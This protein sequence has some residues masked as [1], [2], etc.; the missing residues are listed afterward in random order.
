MPIVPSSQLS[1]LSKTQLERRL[2]GAAHRDLS[3]SAR[4]SLRTENWELR[5]ILLLCFIAACGAIAHSQ[6]VDVSVG[7]SILE[8]PKPTSASLAYI[9]PADSGGVFAGGTLQYLSEN[10]RGL[11]I[12]GAFR[13]K[14][15]LYNGYQYFRPVLYDANYVYARRFT[16]KFR[17]DFMAGIGGETLIFYQKTAFCAYGN[18]CRTYTNDTHFLL[19]AGFGLRYRVFH[20]I[21]VRPEAHYYF[22]PNNYEFHS[23]HVLRVGAS[24]GYTFG[25]HY[26]KRRPAPPAAPTPPSAQQ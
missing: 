15:G 23:D 8:S 11:N 25:E 7:G 20:N 18:G 22:I 26:E 1:V 2:A 10:Y 14:E 13:A 6:Q 17:G 9:P 5:T 16:P 4:L 24:I 21:F 3:L 12:E 19:H